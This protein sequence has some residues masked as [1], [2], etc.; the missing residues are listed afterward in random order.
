MPF[1]TMSRI[2][3]LHYAKKLTHYIIRMRE[4][5]RQNA[6]KQKLEGPSSK[7]SVPE[8]KTRTPAESAK[9]IVVLKNIF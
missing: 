6:R 5:E 4:V 9:S 8:R 7:D 2:L 3:A 1:F